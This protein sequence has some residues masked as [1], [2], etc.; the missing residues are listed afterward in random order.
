MINPFHPG[1]AIPQGAQPGHT[2]RASVGYQFSQ[3]DSE[4]KKALAIAFEVVKR[5]RRAGAETRHWTLDASHK[6][7]TL[8]QQSR[9]LVS[10]QPPD[11]R[12]PLTLEKRLNELTLWENN[13]LQALRSYITEMGQHMNNLKLLNPP[14]SSHQLSPFIEALASDRRITLAALEPLTKNIEA[15]VSL[16]NALRYKGSPAA[17]QGRVF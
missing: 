16:K 9:N 17:S 7:R 2:I 11:T 14:L 1:P 6:T 3:T 8:F 13:I 10:V 12:Y 4:A 15:L 5:A